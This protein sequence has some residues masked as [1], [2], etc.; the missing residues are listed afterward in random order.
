MLTMYSCIASVQAAS[1][2][3][4]IKLP[5]AKPPVAFLQSADHISYS[6]ERKSSAEQFLN[7]LDG[8]FRFGLRGISRLQ[9]IARLVTGTRARERFSHSRSHRH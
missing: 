8:L 3:G 5:M 9:A 4:Y 6:R 7:D 1:G 2:L